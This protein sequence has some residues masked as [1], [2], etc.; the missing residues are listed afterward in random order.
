MKPGGQAIVSDAAA[1]VPGD[2]VPE[3]RP[4]AASAAVVAIVSHRTLRRVLL[5][6]REGMA[7]GSRDEGV[8][9]ML[10]HDLAE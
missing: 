1:G 5:L 2:V 6:D 3:A 10:H 4:A 9:S 8:A 7:G